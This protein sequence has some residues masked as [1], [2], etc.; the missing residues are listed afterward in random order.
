[1]M[2]D[3]EAILSV[4][5]LIKDGGTWGAPGPPTWIVN[6][7]AFDSGTLVMGEFDEQTDTAFREA[8]ITIKKEDKPDDN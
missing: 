1:M 2:T 7:H 8:G 5:R 3:A 4:W 6:K